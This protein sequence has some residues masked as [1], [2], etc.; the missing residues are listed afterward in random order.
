MRP[1]K[2]LPNNKMKP[3]AL[4]IRPEKGLIRQLNKKVKPRTLRIR[5]S[6]DL[7]KKMKPRALMNMPEKVLIKQLNKIK[8]RV[9]TIMLDKGLIKQPKKKMKPR[10]LT[11]RPA[12]V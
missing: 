2:A 11:I 10:D 12:K 9:F 1:D 7:I 5:P 4:T 8:L 6:K 3:R